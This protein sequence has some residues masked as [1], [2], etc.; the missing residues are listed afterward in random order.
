M[1]FE[2]YLKSALDCVY[3]GTVKD[4]MAY[5][6][7]ADGKRVRP[8][9]LLE[10]LKDYGVDESLGY[11]AAAAIEMVHTYSLIHDDL[12]AMDNDDYRR[13]KPSCHKAFDEASA[14]LAGD[15]LLTLAFETILKSDVKPKVKVALASLLARCAGQAGMI[16]GQQLDLESEK[17]KNLSVGEIMEIDTYKTSR[18]LQAPLMA[19]ALL[20]GHEEDLDAMEDLGLAMGL[21][22]QIQDDI[23][24]VTESAEELGKSNSDLELEK[25]TVVSLYGMDKS[26]ELKEAYEKQMEEQLEKLHLKPEGLRKIIDSLKD[27]KK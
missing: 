15:A 19:A 26:I 20:A 5:S 25:A 23:L 4:A 9:L 11:P 17:K 8:R 7:F 1:S 3:N 14:I 21:Q 6:L 10:A 27:R 13:G 16:Y 2:S 22:F 24:A 12:P 18:L